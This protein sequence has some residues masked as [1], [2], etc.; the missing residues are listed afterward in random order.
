MGL[1]YCPT[2]RSSLILVKLNFPQ[3]IFQISQETWPG[4]SHWNMAPRTSETYMYKNE[5]I[6][7]PK[8]KDMLYIINIF[9]ND[10]VGIENNS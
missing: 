7:K 1:Y 4:S 9:E 2:Y 8:K 3:K 6:R 5:D 10:G